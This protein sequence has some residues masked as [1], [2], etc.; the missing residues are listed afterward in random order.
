MKKTTLFTLVGV[1]A[2]AIAIGGYQYKKQQAVGVAQAAAVLAT[3]QAAKAAPTVEFSASDL[4]KITVG[5]IN[6]SIPLTGSLKP[7]NQA[8]IKTKIA[9]ELKSFALREGMSVKA[10]QMIA[11]IDAVEAQSRATEREAQLRSASAQAEQAKRNLDN[12]KALLDKN[13]ISQSAFDTTKSSYDVALANRD[14][15]AQ[16]LVQGRKSLNDTR[17][18]SPIN[19]VIAERYAQP[20]EKLGID[21]R[22]VLVMDLSRMEIE[23]AVP[24]S[25]IAQ[26]SVGQKITLTVEGVTGEQIGTVV[27]IAPTTQA[28][29]RSIP[30]YIA[31]ENRNPQIRAGMFAQGGLAIEA[32]KGAMI[33]PLSALREVAGRNFVYFIESDKIIEREVKVGL[34]D[35]RTSASNGSSGIA[36]ITQGL[37]PNDEIVAVNLG[38]LAVGAV[39]KRIAIV[40]KTGEL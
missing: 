23:A 24:A 6:R 32:R 20:G 9:G 37:K 34:R 12:N 4:M 11:Q 31:L 30:I 18:I 40:K 17:I 35:D 8:L 33:I 38:P 36:E 16:Q 29:T 15:I 39:V 1:G 22:V 27:R 2:I 14:A 10:G 7:V 3:T 25:D 28:G 26:V 5:E 21:S 19:G 13:F